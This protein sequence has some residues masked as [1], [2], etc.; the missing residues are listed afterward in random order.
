MNK[1]TFPEVLNEIRNTS[2]RICQLQRDIDQRKD[3]SRWDI[4]LSLYYQ[5]RRLADLELE[6]D[7]MINQWTDSF[8]IKEKP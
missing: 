2:A 1:L 6:Q 5:K 3:P 4:L 7:N 8:S